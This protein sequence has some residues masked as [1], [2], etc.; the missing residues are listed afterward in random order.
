MKQSLPI[1]PGTIDHVA[2]EVT[3]IEDIWEKTQK[4]GYEALE[5]R[6]PGTWIVESGRYGI[7]PYPVLKRKK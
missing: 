7:L 4:L 2:L 1:R 5:G 3:D 6:S